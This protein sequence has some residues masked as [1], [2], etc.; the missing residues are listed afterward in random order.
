MASVPK[1]NTALIVKVEG[2]VDTGGGGWKLLLVNRSSVQSGKVGSSPR[3]PIVILGAG[4]A[5]GFITDTHTDAGPL[6]S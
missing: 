4:G 1:G 2:P 5:E 6:D 3:Q